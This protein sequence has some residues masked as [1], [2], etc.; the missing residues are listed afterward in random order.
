MTTALMTSAAIDMETGDLTQWDSTTGANIVAS[1]NE[2]IS[3]SYSMLNNH[4][5]STSA[6]QGFAS[7][8]TVRPYGG[9]CSR[10]LIKFN[11]R[12]QAAPSAAI[13]ILSSGGRGL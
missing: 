10:I 7:L 6:G 2:L 9:R 8:T 4:A 3:G 5:T 1:A 13:N 12:P 11:Y